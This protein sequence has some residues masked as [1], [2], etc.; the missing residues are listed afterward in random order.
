MRYLTIYFASKNTSMAIT[1]WHSLD[2]MACEQYLDSG[3]TY[4]HFDK[5]KHPLVW[6]SIDAIG[7]GSSAASIVKLKILGRY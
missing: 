3:A 4:R 2:A 7:M 1:I 6:L 5:L